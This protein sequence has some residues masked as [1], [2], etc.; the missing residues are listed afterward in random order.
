[1]I[2]GRWARCWPAAATTDGLGERADERRDRERE[3]EPRGAVQPRV[4][5]P[6][7]CGGDDVVVNGDVDRIG[8]RQ[9]GRERLGEVPV[10]SVES[11][12]GGT[13]GR[14]HD[15]GGPTFDRRRVA[16]LCVVE[17]ARPT[18]PLGEP[19]LGVCCAGPRCCGERVGAQDHL[20]DRP[21]VGVR[22]QL[23][24][25]AGLLRVLAVIADESAQDRDASTSG[26]RDARI[27]SFAE[28]A[29]VERE[30]ALRIGESVLARTACGEQ[31]VGVG[32]QGVLDRRDTG[33]ECLRIIR[34]EAVDEDRERDQRMEHQ[35]WSPLSPGEPV[36]P[37][38]SLRWMPRARSF[39]W[40][41]VRSI[42]S[43]CAVREMFQSNSANRIRMNSDSTSSRNSRRLLPA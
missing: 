36:E 22:D 35:S 3:R 5:A 34:G 25:T 16:V 27:G 2:L 1:M 42:P 7:A 30:G 21:A 32:G 11:A 41:F 13:T 28:H 26:E 4:A 15:T 39:L 43:A 18:Q 23:R 6:A 10:V 40:R 31:L 14:L 12:A 9:P 24:L 8:R 17:P 38:P 33:V 37:L 29:V 20:V 19:E